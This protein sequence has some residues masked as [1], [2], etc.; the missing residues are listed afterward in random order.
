MVYD[1]TLR[2][3]ASTLP[4]LWTTLSRPSS[5]PVFPLSQFH[6]TNFVI[7]E[8]SSVWCETVPR[9][10][11]Q[12]VATVPAISEQHVVLHGFVETL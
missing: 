4:R 9:R 11:M 6:S 1:G 7:D 8:C 5:W 10:A 12:R 2:F 3:V